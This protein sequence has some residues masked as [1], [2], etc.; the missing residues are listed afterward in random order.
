MKH[1]ITGIE[2]AAALIIAA[3]LVV[4]GWLMLAVLSLPTVFALNA[5]PVSTVVVQIPES[6]ATV[7][8][9]FTATASPVVAATPAQSILPTETAQPSPT[10]TL[11]ATATPLSF[12]FAAHHFVIGQ[13]VEG[14]D[15]AGVAFPASE[16]PEQ[17][18]VLVNGIHGDEMNSAPVVE[19]LLADVES[20]AMGLPPGL[21]LFVIDSLNPDG[22]SRGKRLNAN[23]IDLNRNW[24]TYDWKPGVEIATDFFLP[25]GGGPEPFS[26]PE[27]RAL[28]DWLLALQAEYGNVTLIYFHSAFPP[29]GLVMPGTH[30]TNSVELGDAASREVGQVLAEAAGYNYS[31]RWLGGYK[32][33]G[34]ASTWAVDH[35]M[36]SL[37]VELPVRE[38]LDEAQAGKLREGI[39]A[40]INFLSGR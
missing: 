18:L 34:D 23:G 7:T 21:G 36:R 29:N 32:V 17:A 10:A 5:L 15:I 27:T 39:L 33:T 11:T 28:R 20:G 2:L 14:R 9:P 37:T 3:V 1:S 40:V 6:D 16:A 24:E 13:S 22:A 26:E 12:D 35:L 19:Q 30:L 8:A 25:V 38:A 4:L 31:N